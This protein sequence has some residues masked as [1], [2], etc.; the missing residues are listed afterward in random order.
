MQ[1][2]T[3]IR[4]DLRH[5]HGEI[6]HVERAGDAAVRRHSKAAPT[7]LLAAASF[8]F[9]AGRSSSKGGHDKDQRGDTERLIG[10]WWAGDAAKRS[11]QRL[12]QK[13]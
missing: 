6:G 3:V 10:R 8:R 12:L 4:R 5:L 9:Q 2:R 1:D 7:L 11:P 13:W